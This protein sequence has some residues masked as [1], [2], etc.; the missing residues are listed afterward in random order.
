[1]KAKY[2]L[3]ESGIPARP[4][5]SGGDGVM[6]REMSRWVASALLVALMAC[7]G[8]NPGS[9]GSGPPTGNVSPTP[10]PTPT[11]TPT[12]VPTP[13]PTP[14]PSPTAAPECGDLFMRLIRPDAGVTVTNNPQPV[15]A[16]V[17]HSVV[18]VD[19]YYHI[20][21]FGL[22]GPS[23]KAVMDPPKLIATRHGPPWRVNWQLPGGCGNTVSL[24]AIGF[25]ACGGGKDSPIVTVKTCKP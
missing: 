10:V 15:E 8:S 11:P 25:D 6:L 7:G 4:V 14:E 24:L 5:A 3:R 16:T 12:P 18:R 13:T 9:P 2:R 23:A 19:F 17:G 1:M 21:A 22:T 20:D